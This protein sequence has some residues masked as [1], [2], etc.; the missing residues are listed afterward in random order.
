MLRT[1]VLRGLTTHKEVAVSQNPTQPAPDHSRGEASTTTMCPACGTSVPL[2]GGRIA[3]HFREVVC[4]SSG[5][6]AGKS[7][8]T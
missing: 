3:K 6:S 5:R 2:I 1:P 7:P 8:T 4:R